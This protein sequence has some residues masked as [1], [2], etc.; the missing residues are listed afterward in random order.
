M[1]AQS[2]ERRLKSLAAYIV[3]VDVD[4]VRRLAIQLFEHRAGLV[5]EGAVKPALCHEK[6]NLL[7]RA[8]RSDRAAAAQLGEL[9][10]HIADGAGGSRN[11]NGV[12]GFDLH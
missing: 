6:P 4:P 8:G 7:R 10:R 5:I 11:E 9:T 2:R 12:A 3:E 1:H